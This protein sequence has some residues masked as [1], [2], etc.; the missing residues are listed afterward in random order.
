MIKRLEVFAKTDNIT[1]VLIMQLSNNITKPLIIKVTKT[2]TTE[3]TRD[4]T[5]NFIWIK[6]ENNGTFAHLS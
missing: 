1:E 3:D 6:K 2:V 5:K 4:A